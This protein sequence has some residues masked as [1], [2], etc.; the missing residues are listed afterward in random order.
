M[1]FLY[2]VPTIIIG[3]HNGRKTLPRSAE[4]LLQ[5]LYKLFCSCLV[6]FYYS[7]VSA[8]LIPNLVSGHLSTSFQHCWCLLLYHL[9]YCISSFF[10]TYS[11]KITPA[12]TETFRLSVFPSIGIITLLS[13]MSIISFDTPFASFPKTI[14]FFL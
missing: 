4:S 3:T 11:Y 7:K 1:K 14:A 2:N 13:D 10:L 9:Y 6:D 12:A 5:K 8:N